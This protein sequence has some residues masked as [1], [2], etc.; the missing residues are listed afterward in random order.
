MIQQHDNPGE[1]HKTT[2]KR[3]NKTNFN[4]RNTNTKNAFQR[5]RQFEKEKPQYDSM[6]I[7][8][9]CERYRYSVFNICRI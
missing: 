3:I 5:Q 6:A 4:K 9:K 2:K 8:D 1:G 7:L